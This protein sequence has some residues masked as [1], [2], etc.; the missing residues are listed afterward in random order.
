LINRIR[1]LPEFDQVE[2]EVKFR[3]PWR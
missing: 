2:R 3:A 1:D